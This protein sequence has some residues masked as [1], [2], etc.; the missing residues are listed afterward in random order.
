VRSVFE[1]SAVVDST[2]E[3]SAVLKLGS[4]E[5]VAVGCALPLVP[6]VGCPSLCLAYEAERSLDLSGH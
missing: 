4:T 3:S 6:L 1:S 2:L 5:S